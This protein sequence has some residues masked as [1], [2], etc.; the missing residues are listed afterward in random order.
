MRPTTPLDTQRFGA[1]P[2]IFADVPALEDARSVADDTARTVEERCNSLDRLAEASDDP[3]LKRSCEAYRKAVHARRFRNWSDLV[4]YAGFAV[5][6]VAGK[7]GE[8]SG[9]DA[10]ARQRLEAFCVASH[11]L[12]LLLHCRSEA[13]AHDRVYFPGDWMRS[14]GVS[15]GD[16]AARKTGPGVRAVLDRMLD[17]MDP[18]FSDAFAAARSIPDAEFAAGRD[19]R[20]R[21]AAPPRAA[22]AP[23]RPPRRCGGPHCVRSRRG[24]VPDP[25]SRSGANL[26]KVHVVGAGLSGLACAL[27]LSQAG[28][29]VTIYEAAGHAGGRCRSFFDEN[30]GCTIDNGSHMM[31]GANEATRGYLADAGSED[32]VTEIAPAAFPFVDVPS[33]ATWRVAPGSGPIPF[34]LLDRKRRVAGSGLA[35]YFE[36]LRLA[37]A[38][39]ADTVSDR[40]NATGL[41]YE[42]FWQPLSRAVLNTDASEGSARLLWRMVRETFLRGEKACR[43]FFFGN[44]LSAALVDPVLTTLADRGAQ[45]RFHTRLRAIGVDEGRVS[46]LTFGEHGIPVGDDETVVL[47]VPPDVCGSLLP[48]FTPPTRSNPILNAHYLLEEPVA[49]PWGMP[50][51]GLTGAEAQWLFVR[52][53]SVSVTV[54]AA[55]RLI[56]RSSDALA[57]LLWAEIAPVLGHRPRPAPPCRIIKERRATIA[58]TPS[59]IARRPAT[60][61]ALG[62]LLLAGDWIDTGLP[63]TIEGSIRSGFRSAQLVLDESDRVRAA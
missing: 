34:W 45:I 57:D 47:A 55:D 54:S 60:R 53:N 15:D 46:E 35:D 42:R 29:R 59:E 7:F 50:F 61:T 21:G 1:W 51:L 36:I 32:A 10:S 12:D 20:D 6:P 5:A 25:I 28:A 19:D 31:L 18:V 3:V 4:S 43:P 9:L 39:A 41:L 63:A 13:A 11:L 49:L 44:G 33:G 24:L 23:G 62:N 14:A 27:K 56:D 37:R 48:E 58:Q 30:L 52:G 40:V 2:D 17:R 8:T 16:F 26:T 38:E 22:A